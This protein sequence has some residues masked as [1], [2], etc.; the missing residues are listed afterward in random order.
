M[1]APPAPPAPPKP[2]NGN[3]VVMALRSMRLKRKRSEIEEDTTRMNVFPVRPSK[4][5]KPDGVDA[6]GDD[7]DINNLED[8]TA[9]PLLNTNGNGTKTTAKLQ[10]PHGGDAWDGDGDD[11]VL[12]D[13]PTP[14]PL[15]TTKNE[16]MTTQPSKSTQIKGFICETDIHGE[17]S[18]ESLVELS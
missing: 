9:P 1:E 10:K 18:G 5:H 2:R 14:P 12:E 13:T 7:G 15:N 8:T 6:R 4:L 17:P 16:T 3:L 11:D